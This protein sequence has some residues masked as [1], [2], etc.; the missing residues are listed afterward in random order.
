VKYSINR[1]AKHQKIEYPVIGVVT[2]K[3]WAIAQDKTT[4][5]SFLFSPLRSV[6][7]SADQFLVIEPVHYD[8]HSS[9]FS[10]DEHSVNTFE[11]G[12]P[13]TIGKLSCSFP[14]FRKS[15]FQVKVN[16]VQLTL[17][18]RNRVFSSPDLNTHFHSTNNSLEAKCSVIRPDSNPRMP[19]VVDASGFIETQ[20]D[21]W[22]TYLYAVIFFIEMEMVHVI[23][24]S[25]NK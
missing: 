2:G 15:K 5:A 14:T 20:S 25:M 3:Q 22:L 7:K 21:E 23:T 1:I 13:K 12:T 8:Q 16:D 18:G 19:N 17:R 4:I 6:Y 24:R 11:Q 10:H 9:A